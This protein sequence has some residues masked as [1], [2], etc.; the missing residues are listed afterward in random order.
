M[1]SCIYVSPVCCLDFWHRKDSQWTVS[2]RLHLTCCCE[3]P[4]WALHWL[5]TTPGNATLDATLES[6][7]TRTHAVGCPLIGVLLLCIPIC[8]AVFGVPLRFLISRSRWTHKANKV[9]S[10]T[11]RTLNRV[12]SLVGYDCVLITSLLWGHLC[13]T[14]IKDDGSLCGWDNISTYLHLS[15]KQIKTDMWA[16]CHSDTWAFARKP[17]K[18]SECRWVITFGSSLTTVQHRLQ[19]FITVVCVQSSFPSSIGHHDIVYLLWVCIF[20]FLIPSASVVIVLCCCQDL[21]LWGILNWWDSPLLLLWQWPPTEHFWPHWLYRIQTS[22]KEK[23]KHMCNSLF[24]HNCCTLCSPGE[25]NLS[26]QQSTNLPWNPART[27][28]VPR[29]YTLEVDICVFGVN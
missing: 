24:K 15:Q 6:I 8:P 3:V 26:R 27:F 10:T 22:V 2:H 9:A 17:A 4:H 16:A 12:G 25:V 7:K 29:W 1:V 21:D 11:R 13:V 5:L 18:S 19:A 28:M 23:V 20:L 14:P